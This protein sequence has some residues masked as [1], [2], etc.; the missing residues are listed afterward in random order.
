[1]TDLE[2]AMVLQRIRVR[3]AERYGL[4]VDEMRAIVLRGTAD[5]DCDPALW[6]TATVHA[7]RG[8]RDCPG[9]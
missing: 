1:M 4:T 8:G 6:R 7:R 3:V 9:C 5:W 2:A